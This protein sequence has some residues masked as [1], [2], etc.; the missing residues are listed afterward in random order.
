MDYTTFNS[1][2]AVAQPS[3][4]ADGQ[5]TTIRVPARYNR[6]CRIAWLLEHRDLWREVVNRQSSMKPQSQGKWREIVTRMQRDGVVQP[7]THWS[8][9]NLVSLIADARREVRAF[10]HS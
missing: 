4:A 1:E 10:R 7:T 6:L 9:V 8:D 2:A 3:I 5:T